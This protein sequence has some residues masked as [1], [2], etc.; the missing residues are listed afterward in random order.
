MG[1]IWAIGKREF[2]SFFNS[3]IAYFAITV[4]LFAIGALFFWQREFIE[5]GQATMRPFF[6][7]APWLFV[8]LLPAIS[9]RLISEE[10]RTGSLEMLITMPVRD[11]E[12]IL[13]KLLGAVLFLVVTLVLT[14][15]Y[16]IAIR[17]FG[18][19]DLGPVVGGYVGLLL[20]GITFLSIGLM[21]SVW[22]KNQIVA[23]LLAALFCGFLYGLDMLLGVFS[24][25]LRDALASVSMRDHFETIAKGVLDSRG[26]LYYLSV[27]AFAV[28]V[29]T[30]SLESRRWT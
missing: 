3:P 22:T 25:G 18:P 28:V 29:G 27:T 20:I 14:L 8:G 2:A 6:E 21:A 23:F 5:N 12:L 10:K 11:V 26:I 24:S 7:L 9:M 13:G 15:A 4:F 19:I 1:N 30:Y 16:P 17:M